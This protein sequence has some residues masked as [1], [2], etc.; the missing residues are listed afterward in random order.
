M[1]HGK[2]VKLFLVD[3]T[4]NGVL[5]AEIINWTGHILSAP[6]TKLSDMIKREECKQSTGIYFLVGENENNPL[7]PLVYIGE[8]DN[9]SSRLTQ[10]NK[11]DE[12]GGKGFWNKVCVVTGK[13]QNITKAHIKYLES[14]L[15]DIAIS[16]GK[17]ELKNG[18]A[19]IYNKLP[20]SDTA[21]MEYFLE[22]IQVILPVLGYDFLKARSDSKITSCTSEKLDT[23][24]PS[25]NSENATEQNCEFYL[26]TKDIQANARV[27]DG[28]FYVLKGSQV[29]KEVSQPEHNYMLN[30]R[31]SLLDNGTIDPSAFVFTKDYLFNSPSAA[32]AIILGR[33]CNGRKEWKQVGTDLSFGEWQE[34]QVNGEYE[35]ILHLEQKTEH[36]QNLYHQF[37][38][39]FLN[40]DVGLEV[41]I[42]KKYIAFK[43]NDFNI[44]TMYVFPSKI[45]INLQQ[46]EGVFKDDLG[47]LEYNPAQKHPFYTATHSNDLESITN[48]VKKLADF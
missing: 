15:I 27:I 20:E 37:K 14:R 28:E 32:G 10:H 16:N 1:A 6:R 2:S 38:Q 8:S 13:D 46:R 9:I 35:E 18:T 30:L 24:E 44:I 43:K 21:D 19:H 12:N 5:T 33:S 40:L 23:D 31:P 47:L 25:F 39:A 11:T 3:G 36:I 26:N 22:Q 48:I 29:R 45:H 7:Y 4:P 34:E 17:C 41:V 42:K